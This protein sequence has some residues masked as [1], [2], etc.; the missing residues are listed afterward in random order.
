MMRIQR[1]LGLRSQP[2]FPQPATF[3]LL[4]ALT[5]GIFIAGVSGAQAPVD[6]SLPVV[7]AGE[8]HLPDVYKAWLEQDVL[9]IIKPEER[10]KFLQLSN[11]PE[12][13]RFI[14]QFWLRRDPA[15]ATTDTY[16]AEHYRRLAYA[17]QHFGGEIPGWKTPQGRAYILTGAVAR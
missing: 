2:V 10:S 1:I 7:N 15:G 4:G 14:Q 6:S 17:N 5:A 3:L 16:K 9:W 12:R 8:A 13:D 11:D